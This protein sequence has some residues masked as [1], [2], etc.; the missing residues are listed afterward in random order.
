MILGTLACIMLMP[1]RMKAKAASTEPHSWRSAVISWIPCAGMKNSTTNR[2][3]RTKVMTRGRVCFT[4]GP[5]CQEAHEAERPV[6]DGCG[7]ARERCRAPGDEPAEGGHG[8]DRQD[9]DLDPV[10][11]LE[12]AQELG[13]AGHVRRDGEEL[14][15]DDG[16][17]AG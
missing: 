11:R 2:T 10:G 1:P 15:A 16:V 5:R 3:P 8:Q 7:H 6:G 9:A 12:G 4:S 13:L 17:V 14:L